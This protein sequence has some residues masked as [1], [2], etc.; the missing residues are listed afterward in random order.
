MSSLPG[1]G[2][3][4]NTTVEF[5]QILELSPDERSTSKSTNT[6]FI[7]FLHSDL[8]LTLTIYFLRHNTLS[9]RFPADLNYDLSFHSSSIVFTGVNL[10]REPHCKETLFSIISSWSYFT[11]CLHGA[12]F[13]TQTLTLYLIELNFKLIYFNISN[14]IGGYF[15]LT[16]FCV[17]PPLVKLSQRLTIFYQYYQIYDGCHLLLNISV[18]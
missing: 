16:K 11:C 18:C 1:E 5:N 12:T 2:N 3:L 7:S 8:L 6:D 17:L 13:A 9:R 10:A 14:I 15:K 4:V